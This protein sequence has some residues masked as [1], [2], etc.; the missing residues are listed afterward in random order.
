LHSAVSRIFNP[1]P[2]V[3]L[4][5]FA[6]T[7]SSE[8]SLAQRPLSIT[9]RSVRTF[10]VVLLSMP[11]LCVHTVISASVSFNQEIAP[12]I[13][14]NCSSCHR[15]GEAAPFPLLSY[16]DVVKKSKMI[17]KV[18][19]SRLMPPWKAEPASYAYRDERR[20]TER[21]IDLIQA[22]IKEGTPEGEG[23]ETSA[24]EVQFRL[25]PR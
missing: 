8:N 24:A 23:G 6:R 17:G 7:Q 2:S 12:I 3:I 19:R 5:C 22:W 4:N 14:R 13:Y 11:L 15:P 10:P 20:L 21:E 16:E 25:A 18:T 1:H 9:K